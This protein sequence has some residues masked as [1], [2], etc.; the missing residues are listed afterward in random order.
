MISI[1]MSV[2]QM[3]ARQIRYVIWSAIFWNYLFFRFGHV[4][5]IYVSLHFC[6]PVFLLLFCFSLLF[7]F[8]NPNQP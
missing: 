1:A 5:W 8:S 3:V 7:R 6:F 4:F 2:Y